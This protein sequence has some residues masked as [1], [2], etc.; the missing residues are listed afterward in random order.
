MD[1][2]P[3]ETLPRIDGLVDWGQLEALVIW[4]VLIRMGWP[5]FNWP[6]APS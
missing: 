6:C 4:G 2:R 1:P 5:A 3:G